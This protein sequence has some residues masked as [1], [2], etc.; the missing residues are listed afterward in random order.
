MAT[1]ESGQPPIEC[2]PL[3]QEVRSS[4]G[5]RFSERRPVLVEVGDGGEWQA[6]VTQGHD[7]LQFGDLRGQV[8]PVLRTRI[9]PSRVE[10]PDAVVMP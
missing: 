4:P 6:K 10:E 3:R 1:G 7:P 8:I 5:E 9:H 2:L